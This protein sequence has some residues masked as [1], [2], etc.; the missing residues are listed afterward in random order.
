MVS[1][2]CAKERVA[3]SSFEHPLDDVRLVGVEYQTFIVTGIAI[4]CNPSVP[5]P[6][7]GACKHLIF[8]PLGNHLALE[9]G[10]IHQNI[11][12]QPSGRALENLSP[13]VLELYACVQRMMLAHNQTT[14]TRRDICGWTGVPLAQVRKLL[15]Q[16]TEL[17][18]L[19]A[20]KGSQGQEYVYQL[21][22]SPR[23]GSAWSPGFLSL[24]EGVANGA[25]VNGDGTHD[26]GKPPDS[27]ANAVG[28]SVVQT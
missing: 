21:A 18:Y 26:A 11:P 27:P 5:Q 1:T 17:G 24:D 12:E 10:E 3:P 4:G 22:E 28:A 15:P 20:L 13:K 23:P 25:S 8:R 6:P 7:L 9:L 14:L 2:T 19:R 16:L